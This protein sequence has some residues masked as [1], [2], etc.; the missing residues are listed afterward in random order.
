M[1]IGGTHHLLIRCA[2]TTVFF[3]IASP[4]LVFASCCGCKATASP[5]QNICIQ[6]TKDCASL[7][8]QTTN[9]AIKALGDCSTVLSEAQ[10]KPIDKGVCVS[11]PMDEAAYT[12]PVSPSTA[13]PTSESEPGGITPNIPIPG[14]E[15]SSDLPIVAGELTVPYLAQYISSIQ[16]YLLGIVLTAAAVMIVYG[17]FLYILSSS[18]ANV[19]SG[20][21][22]LKNAVIGLLLVIGAY[23][24]LQ[25]INPATIT[26]TVLRLKKIFNPDFAFARATTGF[27]FPPADEANEAAAA[28]QPVNASAAPPAPQTGENVDIR[29]INAQG[30]FIQRLSAYCTRPREDTYEAKIQALVQVVLGWKS[31]C[32]GEPSDPAGCAYLRGGY[33]NL[34]QGKILTGGLDTPFAINFLQTYVGKSPSWDTSCSSRWAGLSADYYGH[35]ADHTGDYA[36][37]TLGGTCNRQITKQYNE[38]VSKVYQDHGI[39]GGDCGTTIVQMYI[40]AG[41]QVARGTAGDPGSSPRAYTQGTVSSFAT[42]RPSGKDIVAWRASNW[43]DLQKQIAAAGGLKFGDIFAIGSGNFQHNFI[44]TGGRADVPF[45]YFEMGGSGQDGTRGKNVNNL[46]SIPISGMTAWPNGTPADFWLKLSK[47]NLFPVY[48]W[49][50][51]DYEPCTSKSEC[52][53]G[54]ACL[55][56]SSDT[57]N[58]QKFNEGICSNKNV[59]HTTRAYFCYNDEQCAKGY[60]CKKPPN[61][62]TGFCTPE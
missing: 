25:A 57:P 36:D 45:D 6:T 50:P 51:Y 1:T 59:C 38:E 26:P 52:K 16:R 11:G 10:C 17:G 24:I 31:V 13:A 9:A 28:Q 19:S 8:D 46:F 34:A 56:T 22:I 21:E 27:K 49:R 47:H 62:T 33:T 58:S 12:A 48:V 37:F 3:L 15:F 5:T 18:G 44:Y 23:T 54:E 4:S 40:C 61:A 53:N 43:D 29:S 20:K 55:C 60:A 32:I 41:G 30:T 14:L 42:S 39:F 2:A 7:K 35:M